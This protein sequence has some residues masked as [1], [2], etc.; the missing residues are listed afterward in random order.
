MGHYYHGS[1][2]IDPE[3]TREEMLAAADESC[4]SEPEYRRGVVREWIEALPDRKYANHPWVISWWGNFRG[5]D[6]RA[7]CAT[8]AKHNMGRV[9][10]LVMVDVDE[11]PDGDDYS[12]VFISD[13]STW[14]EQG[15]NGFNE[16][17]TP[18]CA[19]PPKTK[20]Y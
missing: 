10:T 8:L 12:P 4:A 14:V 15:W 6:A 19:W 11:E 7:F 3:T 13:Y 5:V 20:H 18:H 17:D 2:T 16:Q 9:R 1:I